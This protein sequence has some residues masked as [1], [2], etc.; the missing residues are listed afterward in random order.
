MYIYPQQVYLNTS[1]MI[2]YQI[3]TNFSSRKDLALTYYPS[4]FE[5]YW[6]VARTFAQLQRRAKLGPLPHAVRPTATERSQVRTSPTRGM[7]NSYIYERRYD[8]SLT[9]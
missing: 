9:R 3:Q 8:L 4:E 5:F 2:A 6:F 1:S 7:T